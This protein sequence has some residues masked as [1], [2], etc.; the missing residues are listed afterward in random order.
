MENKEKIKKLL[1]ELKNDIS[2]IIELEKYNPQEIIDVGLEE[3]IYDSLILIFQP[4]TINGVVKIYFD[5]F[6]TISA[7]ILVRIE[8]S[9]DTLEDA[10]KAAKEEYE[11]N[12]KRNATLSDEDKWSYDKRTYEEIL[13]SKIIIPRDFKEA[14]KKS[15]YEIDFDLIGKIKIKDSHARQISGIAYPISSVKDVIFYAEPAC[16]KSCIDLFNKNIKTTMNDT[17]GVIED[18]FVKDAKCFITCDYESL[19]EENKKIFDE[20][21]KSGIARRYMDWNI[22][23]VSIN[24]PCNREETIGEV[25][26]K[27]QAITSKLKEQDVLYGRQS[28]EQFWKHELMNYAQQIPSIYHKYFD[29]EGYSWDDVIAFAEEFGYYYDSKEDILW[30]D[31]SLYDRHIKYIERTKSIDDQIYA[32]HYENGVESVIKK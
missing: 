22:D 19:S 18:G 28:L 31:K 29:K 3:K 10:E 26:Q 20:L 27:L 6:S 11:S 8:N 25:S 9:Y 15:L 13:A 16:I 21:I 5:A 17:E 2:K 1:I 23:S 32:T 7:D 4:I 14:L 12:Q 24:V 30:N